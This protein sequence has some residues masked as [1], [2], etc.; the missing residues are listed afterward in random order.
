MQ[1]ESRF[2]E[3]INEIAELNP[4]LDRTRLEEAF[5]QSLAWW[6]DSDIKNKENFQ[7]HSIEI[8][9]YIARMRLDTSS[10]LAG[11]LFQVK[12][13]SSTGRAEIAKVFGDDVARLCSGLEKLSKLNFHSKKAEQIKSFRKMF[14]AMAKD[15]RVIMIKLAERRRLMQTLDEIQSE[16]DRLRIAEET[17]DIYAPIASRLGIQWMKTMLEDLAFKIL[18][19]DQYQRVDRFVTSNS[20]QQVKTI[21]NVESD[22]K[23]LMRD[24]QVKAEVSGRS[25]HHY[26]IWRKLKQKSL[27]LDQVY[28][29]L[30][31]RIIVE[32][33]EQC[34]RALGLIHAKWR[35][36]QGKFKDYIAM[37]KPNGYRSLHTIV[38]GSNGDRLEIQMRTREMHDIAE[39][40]IAAHW[41]YKET[42]V[43]PKARK[44]TAKEEQQVAWLRQLINMQQDGQNQDKLLDSLE[45]D[46]FSDYLFI[47]TP[48]Q[49]VVELPVDA[50]PV[51]F[52]FAVHTQV[53]LTIT[54]AKVNGR[55]VP[56]KHK[57]KNGDTVEI[58]TSKKQRPKREWLEFVKTNRA[59]NKIRHAIREEEREASLKLGQEMC[60]RQLKAFGLNFNRLS[61]SGDLDE[62]AKHLKTK[63]I[64]ELLISV[65]RGWISIKDIVK[66]IAPE[67]LK[68]EEATPEPEI[69]APQKRRKSGKSGIQVGGIDDVMVRFGKCC[70]PIVGDRIIGFVTRGRG[71]TIHRHTCPKLPKGQEERLIESYWAADDDMEMPVTIKVTARDRIGVIK[72]LSAV[73]AAHNLNITSVRTNTG[74][75]IATNFFRLQIRDIDQLGRVQNHLKRMKNIIRVE[76]ISGH[77]GS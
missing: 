66:Q 68:Q 74:D 17:R 71:L 25:K 58:I 55:I 9:P 76:R 75:G 37:P 69:R 51:D 31:F 15:I 14:L 18:S 59:K 43:Q 38:L 34:Y 35:P 28:D 12:G 62:A 70:N 60:E 32:D 26:S 30:A 46:M 11:L 6:A 64:R 16:E 49:D 57:L 29:L 48:D 44:N 5:H 4:E 13:N 61:K 40:G 54:G 19:P 8:L 65:G 42:G 22:I 73:F 39:N 52:A 36:I 27:E 72:D 33:V 67:L 24:N 1:I 3:V 45:L 56:L 41:R 77:V 50:S 20:S 21:D 7:W 63:D 2:N 23:N 53:G 10:L 47:F